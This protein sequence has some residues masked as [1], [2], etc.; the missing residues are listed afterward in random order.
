MDKKQAFYI[1]Y[2]ILFLTGC[3]WTTSEIT[4]LTNFWDKAIPYQEIPKGLHSLSAKSC[5]EC[6]VAHYRE[7]QK[8]THSQAWT[9][10]QFQAEIKKKNSPTMC[11]NCH[12]PLANQQEELTQGYVDGD[13]FR[14]VSHPNTKFDY[15][16][17]QEGITCAACH[18]RNNKIVGPT[19]APNAPHATVKDT[20]HLSEQ[21]CI[22]CHNA[23]SVITPSLVCSFETGDEWKNGPYPT[24]NKNC[25]T[26][27]MEVTHRAIV[28]KGEPRKSHY[29]TFPGSGIPKASTH[30]PDRLEGLDYELH[31][32]HENGKPTI[33]LTLTN[34]NAGHRVPTG[35]PERFIIIHFYTLLNQEVVDSMTYRIGEVWEWS[36]KAKK[37]SDNNLFPLESRTFDYQVSLPPGD[38]ASVLV[39]VT[40]HRGTITNREYNK[41]SKDYPLSITVFEEKIIPFFGD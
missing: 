14:P 19:G 10:V 4:P 39:K 3:Q 2:L 20:T 30:H 5:G 8:S 12:I 17:Q 23:V 24:K 15:S 11:I 33:S 34:R 36:P 26:C 31:Q 13:V 18:V 6:H 22:S 21:L 16:L 25:K 32:I 41:I 29:H 28:S 38:Q 37:I 7:W 27:H 1:I 35:D 40:K 9:D